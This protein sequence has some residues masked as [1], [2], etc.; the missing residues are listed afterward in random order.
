MN[1]IY[2]R[3]KTAAIYKDKEYSYYE[4]I[5][6]AKIYSS[7]LDIDKED[8]VAVFMENRPWAALIKLSKVSSPISVESKV[9]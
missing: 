4:L 7:L 5:K 1:F 2:D 9:L 3:K 8:R 6:M